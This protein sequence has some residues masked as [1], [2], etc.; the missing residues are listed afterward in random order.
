MQKIRPWLRPSHKCLATGNCVH[1]TRENRL[2]GDVPN[3]C[4]FHHST[5]FPL[6]VQNHNTKSWPNPICLGWSP[7]YCQS[8]VHFSSNP[9]SRVLSL[10]VNAAWKRLCTL[11]YFGKFLLAYSFESPFDQEGL[12]EAQFSVTHSQM[13]WDAPTTEGKV[14]RDWNEYIRAQLCDDWHTSCKGMR[15]RGQIIIEIHYTAQRTSYF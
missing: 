5:H 1:L 2:K 10:I 13:A 6:L 11:P 9:S 15:M 12:L 4:W 7:P 14:T 8:P 3:T